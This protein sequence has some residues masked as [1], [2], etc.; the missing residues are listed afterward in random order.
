MDGLSSA[1]IIFGH[2]ARDTLPVHK[3]AFTP[4]WQTAA[5]DVDYHAEERKCRLEQRYNASARDLPS[6]NTGTKV[7][8]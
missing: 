8:V 6:L 3:R 5:K 7:V 4:E 1:Q 2:P